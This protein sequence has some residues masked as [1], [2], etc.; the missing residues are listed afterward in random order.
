MARQRRMRELVP[1]ERLRGADPEFFTCAGFRDWWRL[2]LAFPFSV[3]TIDSMDYGQLRRWEPGQK[4]ADG[5][6]TQLQHWGYITHLAHDGRFLL[7]RLV[8]DKPFDSGEGPERWWLYDFEAETGAFHP[9]REALLAEAARRKYSGPAE[10][11][12]LPACFDA[13]FSGE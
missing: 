4:V 11:K 5:D 8:G 6:E 7:A 13:Y 12:P 3:H 10:L 1:E 2:P 9:S